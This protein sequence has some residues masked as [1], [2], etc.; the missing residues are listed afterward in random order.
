MLRFANSSGYCLG[1]CVISLTA[2]LL[3]GGGD[4]GDGDGTP[5]AATSSG[6]TGSSPPLSTPSSSA[7]SSSSG[8]SGGS[9]SGSGGGGGD[10]SGGGGDSSSGISKSSSSKIPTRPSAN[11]DAHSS[12]SSSSPSSSSSSSTSLPN[13]LRVYSMVLERVP[14]SS[15]SQKRG[16][17]SGKFSLRF[18]PSA[19]TKKSVGVGGVG[20]V[21]FGGGGGNGGVGVE[22]GKI[23][24]GVRRSVVGSVG[25]MQAIVSSSV[26]K[27]PSLSSLRDDAAKVKYEREK[28]RGSEERAKEREREKEWRRS[29]E[30][31][32]SEEK[33][34]D[35]IVGGGK[36]TGSGG[37]SFSPTS[38]SA[39]LSMSTR[40][41]DSDEA[42]YADV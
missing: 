28:R 22:L 38:L 31:R 6:A 2:L 34:N 36:E 13:P 12:P 5:G 16:F 11:K 15:G 40:Q 39:S 23:G 30:G 20:G 4:G 7:G 41:R 10:F 17:L 24:R 35:G 27:G 32:G 29:G 37:L 33:K 25:H 19:L 9:V 14:L 21:G 26:S 18:L 1:S 8:G 3:A 42:D